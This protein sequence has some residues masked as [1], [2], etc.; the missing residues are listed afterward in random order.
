MKWIFCFR[1]SPN[2]GL[3]KLFTLFRPNF[4]HVYCIR[5]VP[6][7]GFWLYMECASQRMIVEAL[8][9]NEADEVV[10]DMINNCTCVE[11]EQLKET[12]QIPRWLYCVSFATHVAGIRGTF[13]YTPYQL[14]CELLKKGGSIIFQKEGD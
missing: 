7:E 13:I 9:D 12:I 11:I 4:G 6:E 14:Y 5:F 8:R 3:W 10:Y 1:E 2:R